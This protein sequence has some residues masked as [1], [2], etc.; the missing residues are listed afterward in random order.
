MMQSVVEHQEVPKGE[1][2]VIPVAGLGKRR[3]DEN[4]AE[5]RLQK[6]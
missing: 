4:L 2:A 1:A 3:R 6:P 5:E